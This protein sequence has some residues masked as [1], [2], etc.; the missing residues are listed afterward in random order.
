MLWKDWDVGKLVSRYT[1]LGHNSN[2]TS[3]KK[4][5]A[6]SLGMYNPVIIES[7]PVRPNIFFES[8]QRS[9]KG[10]DKLL[11]ILEPLITELKVKRLDFP[12][13][14]IYDSIA[15][16]SNCYSITSKMLGP[17]QY[18]P[19]GSCTVAANRMFTMFHALYPDH[20]RQRTQVC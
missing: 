20:E 5:I 16:I 7:N 14:L 4:E 2:N 15:T 18:E 11:A 10:E 12:L 19:I 3:R 8:K 9:S 13:T 1:N 17:L 6:L